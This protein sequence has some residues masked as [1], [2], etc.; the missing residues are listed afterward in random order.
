M[1]AAQKTTRAKPEPYV[2]RAEEREERYAQEESA[3]LDSLDRAIATASSALK[4]VRK[5]AD[6]APEPTPEPTP[7]PPP[8]PAEEPPAPPA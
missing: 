8:P 2:I 4:A 6:P 1:T 7:E 3:A 5:K